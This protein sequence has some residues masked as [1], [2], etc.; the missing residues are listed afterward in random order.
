MKKIIQNLFN[1]YK[2]IWIWWPGE[3]K[4]EIITSAVLTQLSSRQQ[5]AKVLENLKKIRRNSE[6]FKNEIYWY[7][8]NINLDWDIEKQLAKILLENLKE[9]DLKWVWFYKRKYQ[10]IKTLLKRFLE[11]D[12]KLSTIELRK[13]LLSIKWIWKETADAILCYGLDRKIFVVDEYTYRVIFS[14]LVLNNAN[15]QTNALKNLYKSFKREWPYN[16]LRKK[17]ENI[18]KILWKDDIWYF[19]NLHWAFVEEGK[20]LKFKF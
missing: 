7:N 1:K 5:V 13:Q 8:C 18:L 9:E 3:S 19:K 11:I 12:L 2:H 6:E 15:I 14:N 16:K 10:T 17:I 4:V 20:I